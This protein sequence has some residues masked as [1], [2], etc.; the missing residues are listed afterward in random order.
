MDWDSKKK[1][2]Q[3]WTALMT[4]FD[5]DRFIVKESDRGH[6]FAAA[7][8]ST[9]VTHAVLITPTSST[10]EI[11]ITDFS[12]SS[13]SDT[14]YVQIE[15]S[16]STV[17]YGGIIAKSWAAKAKAMFENSVHVHIGIGASVTVSMTT[18]DATFIAVSY[19]EC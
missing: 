7:E 18:G 12:L 16:S 1:L 10:V 5:E 8:Y 9:N 2:S 3:I 14:G 19:E 11:I 15:S 13:A 4:G 6:L 17:G